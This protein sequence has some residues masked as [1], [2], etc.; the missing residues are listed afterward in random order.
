MIKKITSI[1]SSEN[2]NAIMNDIEYRNI[3]KILVRMRRY[4]E[5]LRFL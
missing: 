5:R 2:I 4:F 1:L 3:D